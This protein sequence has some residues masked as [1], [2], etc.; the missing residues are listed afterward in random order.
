MNDLQ[1]AKGLSWFSIGL[2]AM[3]LVLP[4]AASWRPATW[5]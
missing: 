4:V 1:V 2:G 3:E 5:C